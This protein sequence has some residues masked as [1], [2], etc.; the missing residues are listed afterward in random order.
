MEK[1]GQELVSYLRNKAADIRIRLIEYNRRIG[2]C[3]LGGPLSMCDMVVALYYH[4][5][6]TDKNQIGWEDRDRFI[7]SK[8]H[9]GC[10]ICN[11]LADQ[12]YYTFEEM[13]AECITSRARL[14]VS[15]PTGSHHGQ[16]PYYDSVSS[17]VKWAFPYLL[18]F[19]LLFF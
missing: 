19:Q 14:P 6:K 13:F 9:C 1:Q 10:L 11:I 12:G 4:F 15:E 17:S 8:G 7:L 3:H 18:L 16:K 2:D 5:M